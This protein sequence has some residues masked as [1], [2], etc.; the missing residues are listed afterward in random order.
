MAQRTSWN[1]DWV[2]NNCPHLIDRITYFDNYLE[3]YK[4][5]A[6]KIYNETGFRPEEPLTKTLLT[7]L[8]NRVY[9]DI[10]LKPKIHYKKRKDIW[11]V[12]SMINGVPEDIKKTLRLWTPI[13]R[14]KLN[15]YGSIIESKKYNSRHELLED[16]TA[17][18]FSNIQKAIAGI[19]DGE[20]KKIAYGYKWKQLNN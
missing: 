4:A 10:I 17:G 15:K 11:I 13:E 9:P 19:N 1:T 5:N 18:E 7:K 14:Y 12:R 2:R 6:N 3:D 20:N 8:L 16:Y